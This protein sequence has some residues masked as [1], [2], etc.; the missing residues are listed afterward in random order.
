MG[1]PVP[2]QRLPGFSVM[3]VGDSVL[4]VRVSEHGH[5]Q[6]YA[7]P[8]LPVERLQLILFQIYLDSLNFTK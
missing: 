4:A 8:D 7:S 1:D 3:E 5:V 6:V 2:A